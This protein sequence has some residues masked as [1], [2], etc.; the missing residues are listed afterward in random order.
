VNLVADEGVEASIVAAL[1][2]EGYS[3]TYLAEAAPSAPDTLVLELAR[4]SE[5][6]L[7]TADKDFGELIFRQRLTSSG[8]LLVRLY[9]LSPSAKA[10]VVLGAIRKHGSEMIGAFTV[11]SP[12]V[13]RIRPRL[14]T[15]A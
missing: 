3:V 14:G 2:R 12:G 15:G 7:I 13:V 8:V 4:S 9:S 5:S 10:Q 11:V 1:R 6:L